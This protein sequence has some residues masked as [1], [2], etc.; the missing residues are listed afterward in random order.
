MNWTEDVLLV[1]IK[2]CFCGEIV[3]NN[4]THINWVLT[5]KKAEWNFPIGGNVVTGT[6]GE[7][8]GILCDKCIDENKIEQIK[9]AL[10]F[11]GND[12]EYVELG[13]LQNLR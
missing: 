6:K 13:R 8:M 9:Y 12:V 2:C 4:G 7:A 3:G 1:K 11:T 5:G 10:K